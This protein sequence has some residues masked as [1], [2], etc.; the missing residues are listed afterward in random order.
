MRKIILILTIFTISFSCVGVRN[1]HQRESNIMEDCIKLIGEEK[2]VVFSKLE[3]MEMGEPTKHKTLSDGTEVY[4]FERNI[5]KK[6]SKRY[7][8]RI[9]IVFEDDKMISYEIEVRD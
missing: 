1:I 9:M 5:M 6:G 2:A 4:L 7:F 3:E 8:D